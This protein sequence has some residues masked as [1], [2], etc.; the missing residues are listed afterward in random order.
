MKT[1]KDTISE[2]VDM[3]KRSSNARNYIEQIYTSKM[4]ASDMMA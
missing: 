4:A 3:N 1:L 2:Y